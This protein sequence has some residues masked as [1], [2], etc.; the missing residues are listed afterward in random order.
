MGKDSHRET[1]VAQTSHDVVGEHFCMF[2]HQS[3]AADGPER[4]QSYPVNVPDGG[5][6]QPSWPDDA[7]KM[8]D[9]V[10]VLRTR[11][12]LPARRY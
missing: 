12:T 8:I 5:G 10:A 1:R 7:Q 3:I 4:M 6:S 2:E 11:T 9:A